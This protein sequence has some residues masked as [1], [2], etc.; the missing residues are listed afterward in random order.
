[1]NMANSNDSDPEP[2]PSDNPF[3]R[4]SATLSP[5]PP[6]TFSTVIEDDHAKINAC[7]L[8]LGRLLRES[9]APTSPHRSQLVLKQTREKQLALWDEVTWRLIRHDVSEDIVMRPAFKQYLGR[10]GAEMG[11]HDRADH[12]GAREELLSVYDAFVALDGG[13]DPS[14]STTL[15][16]R[17]TKAEFMTLAKRFK[18]LMAELAEHMKTESG[19]D[20]PRLEGVLGQEESRE[21]GRRYLGTYVLGPGLVLGGERVWKGVREFAGEKRERFWELWDKV[22]GEG[23]GKARGNRGKL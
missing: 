17:E 10:E 8:A 11:E 23:E 21:L 20:I 2:F 9:L 16:Q 15:A 18:N 5:S 3:L 1:M 22:E 7:A 13:V 4:T 19:T 12:D 6:L 14:L